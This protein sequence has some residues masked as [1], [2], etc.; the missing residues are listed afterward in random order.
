MGQEYYSLL[1][2]QTANCQPPLRRVTV[3]PECC[4]AAMSERCFHQVRSLCGAHVLVGRHVLAKRVPNPLLPWA[5]QP[6]GWHSL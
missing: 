2:T 5:L 4:V 6:P 1:L 3:V